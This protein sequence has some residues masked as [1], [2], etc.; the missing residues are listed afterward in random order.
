M[1]EDPFL[2]VRADVGKGGARIVSDGLTVCGKCFDRSMCMSS[3]GLSSTLSS[4]SSMGESRT[5]ELGYLGVRDSVV[6]DGEI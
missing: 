6:S 3:S 2:Y 5:P 1:D 4:K